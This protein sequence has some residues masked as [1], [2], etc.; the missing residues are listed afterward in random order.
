MHFLQPKSHSILFLIAATSGPNGVT[1]MINSFSVFTNIL[2]FHHTLA[3]VLD[4]GFY[5][6]VHENYYQLVCHAV[7]FGGSP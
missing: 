2:R 6:N 3:L 7:S 1:Y 5:S 4:R